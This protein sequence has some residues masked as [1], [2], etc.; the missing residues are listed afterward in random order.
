VKILPDLKLPF[1]NSSHYDSNI[2]RFSEKGAPFLV[3][4][5]HSSSNGLAESAESIEVIVVNKG[6][7]PLDPDPGILVKLLRLLQVL[8]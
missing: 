5:I 4:A 2:L 1:L 7:E 3:Y 6:L 8:A